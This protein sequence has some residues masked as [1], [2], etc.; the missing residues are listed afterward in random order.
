MCGRYSITI[1]SQQIAEIFDVPQPDFSTEPRYNVAPTQVVPIVVGSAER[2]LAQGRWGLVPS[3][4]KDIAIGSKMINARAETLSEK[5]SFRQALQKR[6]CLVPAD[7]FYEWQRDGKKKQPFRITLPGDKTFAFAGLWENWVSPDGPVLTTFTIV[8]TDPNEAVSKLHHRMPA[9][10]ATEKQQ[11][12]W[13]QAENSDIAEM[14]VPYRGE[15]KIYEV[16]TLVNSA[17]T[18]VPECIKTLVR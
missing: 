15:L 9:I 5:V 4:S 12:D 10:L 3:W 14:L 18:D 8:T 2:R 13:L 1:T 6:R 17:L 16:S 11:S 7:G